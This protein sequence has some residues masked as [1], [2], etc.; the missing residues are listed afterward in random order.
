LPCCCQTNCA[1]VFDIV[2][3]G[4]PLGPPLAP[5]AASAHGG[6]IIDRAPG[7]PGACVAIGQGFTAGVPPNFGRVPP[8]PCA[9]PRAS[10]PRVPH[11]SQIEN[12]GL[13]TVA[14]G[15]ASADV[16]L[17]LHMVTA[18]HNFGGN[19]AAGTSPKVGWIRPVETSGPH[20]HGDAVWGPCGLCMRVLEP[21]GGVQSAL[22]VRL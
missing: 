13:G 21:R 17:V 11:T 15:S 9:G 8:H 5:H 18:A 4:L 16:S 3:T 10:P 22:G 14:V 7:V 19:L 12:I 2:N 6:V 1:Q 20:Q